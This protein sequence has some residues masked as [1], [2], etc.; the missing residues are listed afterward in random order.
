MKNAESVSV[1]E[2]LDSEWAEYQQG[3]TARGERVVK[4]LDASSPEIDRLLD[5]SPAWLETQAQVTGCQYQFARMNVL[6]LGFAPGAKHFRITFSYYAHGKSFSSELS[7]SVA[8]EQGRTFSIFYNPLN[9]QQNS[10]MKVS[11]SSGSQ[12][13]ALGVAGSILI[14]MVYLAMMNGCN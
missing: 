14:S 5:P 2:R 11:F 6:T 10:Q 13:Y 8:M 7:S 12:L 3:L 9:P 1:R 4:S